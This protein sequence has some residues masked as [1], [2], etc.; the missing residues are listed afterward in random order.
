MSG[1]SRKSKER[2]FKNR[3]DYPDLMTPRQAAE[4]LGVSVGFLARRRMQTN[5][6]PGP[7]YIKITARMVRYTKSAL[8]AFLALMKVGGRPPPPQKP[9]FDRNDDGTPGAP[10]V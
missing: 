4:Y 8:D 9:P 5:T 3:E 10:S 2:E 1:V 6:K 7:D